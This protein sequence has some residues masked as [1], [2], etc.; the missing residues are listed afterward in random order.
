M[1]KSGVI[2]L[3]L[4]TSALALPTRFMDT[5]QYIFGTTSELP[6][7]EIG[8]TDPRLNGGRFLDVSTS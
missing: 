7:A 2:L 5:L 8:W 1:V 3:A 6:K 4:A